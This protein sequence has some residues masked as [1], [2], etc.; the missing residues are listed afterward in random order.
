MRYNEYAV[1]VGLGLLLSVALA[2]GP[3]RIDRLIADLKSTDAKTRQAA[4]EALLK[5]TDPQVVPRVIDCLH[6][7]NWNVR[8]DTAEVLGRLGD[9]RAVTPLLATLPDKEPFVRMSVARALGALKAP[10]AVGPLIARLKDEHLLVRLTAADM[11]GYLQDARAAEPL[12]ACLKADDAE[13]RSHAV[14]ALSDLGNTQTR[15]VFQQLKQTKDVATLINCLQFTDPV[16]RGFAADALL[17]IGAPAMRPLQECSTNANELI[18]TSAREILTKLVRANPKPAP[19]PQPVVASAPVAA[20][21][22]P[23][24]PVRKV[25]ELLAF[26]AALLNFT[27]S[28]S[29]DSGDD[30]TQTRIEP[31]SE[32]G[33]AALKVVYGVGGHFGSRQSKVTDW[34][35]YRT[36]EFPVF[37]PGTTDVPLILTVKHR[38]TRNYYT[39]ADIP[40]T[41][42]PGRTDVKLPIHTMRNVNTTIPDLANVTR[43]HLACA[44]NTRATIYVG[45]M[46]LT[47][48]AEP[49]SMPVPAPDPTTIQ[50]PPR[51]DRI[52]AA[53]M[54]PVTA[55]VL[56]DT[57]EADAI[58]AALEVFPS[59]NPWNQLVTD[60]PLHPNSQN[61]VASIGATKPLRFNPD[62]GFILVPTDQARV[63]VKIVEYPGESDP[64]PYPVPSNIPIEGWPA[65]YK[66]E[67]KFKDLTLEDVQRDKLNLGGDRHAI[68]LDPLNRMLYEFAGLRLTA[69]GWQAAQASIFDLKTNKLRSDGWTSTD[70]A[71]LPLFP[72]VVRYD[73][74]QRGRIEHALRVTVRKSRKAYVAPATHYASR[75]T[76]ENL[77]RMGERLRLRQDYDLTDFS[78]GARIVLT[79]LKQYGMLVADNGI[80]WAVS[81]APDERIAPLHEELR[82]IRGVDFEVIVAPK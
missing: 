23:P 44:P 69:T 31:N 64:G 59:D 25:E 24:A 30:D 37:N 47:G 56:F 78:P 11:L 79:A 58:L 76:D 13:L 34:T 77:P 40:F 36:L 48:K 18:R 26:K 8:V 14:Q 45:D 10:Q 1:S 4:I 41:V 80:E 60:W 46:Y 70:A 19:V 17:E 49:G 62:M 6:D 57:P 42:K 66:R 75:L 7:D 39:R 67:P 55:P 65:Y 22:P 71:G 50:L 43:W 29:P 3:S 27:A 74:L 82:R 16:L 38:Q 28:E 61:I 54:P 53:K 81:V 2:C 21:A 63:N 15:L 51:L 9:Q 35:P 73:E 12:I 33:A 20:T 72:A 52:H 5:V 68:V 32:L